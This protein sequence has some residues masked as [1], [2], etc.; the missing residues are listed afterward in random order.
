MSRNKNRKRAA[1]AKDEYARDLE[2][3]LTQAIID[4]DNASN[5]AVRFSLALDHIIGKLGP[6]HAWVV[7]VSEIL[8]AKII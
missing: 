4:R 1:G 2:A 3:K 6:D 5:R 7:E 8:E